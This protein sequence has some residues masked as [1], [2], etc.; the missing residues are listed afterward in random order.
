MDSF[1]GTY[2]V[3]NTRTAKAYDLLQAFIEDM[4]ADDIAGVLV[5]CGMGACCEWLDGA[6]TVR[7]HLTDIQ[8]VAAAAALMA[9]RE[10]RNAGMDYDP[11][12]AAIEQEEPG[13]V[14]VPDD[15]ELVVGPDAF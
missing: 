7:L 8:A 11:M 2:P 12:T 13:L 6:T 4:E 3:L 10:A 1:D 15:F 9:L 5:E 14:E